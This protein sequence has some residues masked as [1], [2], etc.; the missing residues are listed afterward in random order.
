[1]CEGW[2]KLNFDVAFCSSQLTSG[3]GVVAYDSNGSTLLTCSFFHQNVATTFT[4][5]ALAALDTVKKGSVFG[6]HKYILEGDY[7]TTIKK[8]LSD[9]P[10]LSKIIPIIRDIKSFGR[11]FQELQL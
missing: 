3:T 7:L 10:D 11:S 6:F 4:V 5:K 1:M 8:R 2:V 9:S